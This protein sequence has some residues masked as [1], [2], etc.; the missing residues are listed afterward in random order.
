VG[1][2]PHRHCR[3]RWLA[4]CCRRWASEQ[5]R[6]RALDSSHRPRTDRLSRRHHMRPAPD[7]VPGLQA[8]V[9][10]FAPPS[11]PPTLT[12]VSSLAY[13]ACPREVQ[14]TTRQGPPAQPER[15]PDTHDEVTLP[16]ADEQPESPA[17]RD[18]GCEYDAQCKG[19]RLCIE[20]Q[21]V[22]RPASDAAAPPG[23]MM[24]PSLLRAESRSGPARLSTAAGF[25]LSQH[26]RPCAGPVDVDVPEVVAVVIGFRGR[27]H[28][29]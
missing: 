17:T 22:D 27:R 20:R 11:S 15:P 10:A 26:L 2:S 9:R 7:L 3:G 1:A 14:G 16:E 18:H 29:G 19:E 25:S 21:C 28:Q 24:R 5:P 12:C 23:T 8:L 6:L 13:G 4:Q